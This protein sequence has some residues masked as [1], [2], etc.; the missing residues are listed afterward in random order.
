VD[1]GHHWPGIASLDHD[2]VGVVRDVEDSRDGSKS[3]EPGGEC[4]EAVR[5][6]GCDESSAEHWRAVAHDAAC[7]EPPHRDRH[8]AG[9]EEEPDGEPGERDSQLARG[10]VSLSLDRRQAW[11]E[12]S[13]RDRVQDEGR[14][15]ASPRRTQAAL[16]LLQRA[17]M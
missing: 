1:A 12:G 4:D 6:G 8:E 2:G 13:C 5:E 15:D 16:A 10:D 3:S 11:S 17:V 14:N 9:S 7:S